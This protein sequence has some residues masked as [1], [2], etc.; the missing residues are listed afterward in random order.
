MLYASRT[1]REWRM[2]VLYLLAFRYKYFESEIKN[3]NELLTFPFPSLFFFSSSGAYSFSLFF[4]G[5]YVYC[6]IQLF[7]H[8][9]HEKWCAQTNIIQNLMRMR[10]NKLVACVLTLNLLPLKIHATDWCERVFYAVLYYCLTAT[11]RNSAAFWRHQLIL[12]ETE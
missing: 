4:I 2:C 1:K 8:W 5:W 10:T 12:G 6:F 7:T 3:H 9:T 11:M